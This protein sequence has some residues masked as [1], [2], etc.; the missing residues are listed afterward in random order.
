MKSK[1]PIWVHLV[2]Y[3]NNSI[4]VIR[5]IRPVFNRTLYTFSI[6]FRRK[7]RSK[8]LSCSTQQA[9]RLR[10]LL[11]SSPVLRT[12]LFC[13]LCWIRRINTEAWGEPAKWATPNGD[14]RLAGADFG[15]HASHI[16]LYLSAQPLA[17]LSPSSIHFEATRFLWML[18]LTCSSQSLDTHSEFLLHN[19]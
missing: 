7:R 19:H 9:T 13:L 1:Q 8:N 12:T 6:R 14:G 5:I 18:Y 15:L 16:D 4:D 2:R 3:G 11:A 17:L 10:S